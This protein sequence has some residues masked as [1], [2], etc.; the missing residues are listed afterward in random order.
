RS[1][2]DPGR[3]SLLYAERSAS[4]ARIADSSDPPVATHGR[5]FAAPRLA[6]REPGRSLADDLRR[7]GRGPYR[8]VW[9]QL[10][11]YHLLNCAVRDLGGGK[12]DSAD[13]KT[14]RSLSVHPV[15]SGAE[16]D[17]GVAGADHH[18]V[19]KSAVA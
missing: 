16:H 4:D 1:K 8:G 12:H 17:Y 19:A 6:Q 18:D 5:A 2:A 15:E 10:E 9:R 7:S 13:A 3:F 14:V 11:V